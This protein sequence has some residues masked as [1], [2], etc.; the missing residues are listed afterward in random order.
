MENAKE[1][2]MGILDRAP[3]PVQMRIYY[4]ARLE[5]EGVTPILIESIK[6]AMR[7]LENDAFGRTGVTVDEDDDEE[8]QKAVN[9]YSSAIGKAADAYLKAAQEAAGQ[10]VKITTKA[11]KK[12][13]KAEVVALK[14]VA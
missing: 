13:E 9:M 3:L 10:T 7:A 2:I 11:A 6:S 1:K 8:I 12:I 4:K 14:Q 5:K